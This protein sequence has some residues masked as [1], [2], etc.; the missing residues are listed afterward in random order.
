MNVNLGI[1]DKLTRAVVV[2][3]FLA[4]LTAVALWYMPAIQENEQSRKKKLELEQK[5]EKEVERSRQ[6]D[7]DSRAMQDP[8]TVE[9]L[10]R[11]RLGLGR[12][13]EIIYQFEPPS[14]NAQ[15]AALDGVRR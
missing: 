8:K 6:L 12:T 1:W 13:G 2:L 11:E 4:A 7:A 9:R 10:A 15:A 5:I 3:L 14:T